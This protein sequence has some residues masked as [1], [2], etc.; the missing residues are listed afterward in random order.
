VA[1]STGEEGQRRARAERRLRDLAAA[2]AREGQELGGHGE[3][4]VRIA[5]RG[6]EPTTMEVL[7][8]RP[9]YQ[10]GAGLRVVDTAAAGE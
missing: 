9:Q 6:G 3:I 8:R 4:T 10:L 1:T 5:Y 2:L 7:S